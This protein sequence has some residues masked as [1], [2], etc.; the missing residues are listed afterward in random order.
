MFGA[1]VHDTRYAFRHLRQS[2]AFAAAAVLTLALGI[3]A[4]TAMFSVLNVLVLR[5]L[6]ITDPHGL[7]AMSAWNDRDQRM[8][9]LITS[10]PELQRDG[11][12]DPVCAFNGGG[13]FPA[14]VGG[15][16]TQSVIALITGRCFDVFG[17]AP[18]LG[19]TITDADAP[20]ERNPEMVAVIGHQ[21]WNRA[22]G[23]DPN[24]IGKTIRMEGAELTVIGV[25]PAGFVGIHAVG[26]IDLFVPNYTI[27]PRRPDRPHG[28]SHLLGRLK[29]GVPFE[30]AKAELEAR[31]PSLL[32]AT[33]PVTLTGSERAQFLETGA[34]V[35]RL[36]TGLSPYRDRYSRPVVIVLGLTLT[37]LLLACL[38]LGGLLLSR[39]AARAPEIAT[40]LALGATRRR[41][42]QQTVIESLYL[43]LSAAALAVP[44]SFGLVRVLVSFLPQPIVAQPIS[45]APDLRVVAVT[46]LCGIVAGVMISILPIW[47]GRR[48]AAMSFAWD[49]TIAGTT[50]RWT[51]G[52][53]VAQVAMSLVLLAG[54]VV[55][56]RS[57]YLLQ[58]ADRGFRSNELVAVYVSPLPNAYRT[59]DNA[60]YYPALLDRIKALPGV[61]SAALSRFFPRASGEPIGQP[62]AIKGEPPS[63]LR[64]QYETVSPGFFETVGVPLVAGRL[65]DWTDRANTQ[66]VAVVSESLARQLRPD[67]HVLGLRVA[68]GNQRA[69]QDVVIVGVVGNMSFGNPRATAFP[70]IYRPT[71]Q[72]G[73]LANNPIV[74]VAANENAPP[75]APSLRDIF[76]DAGREYARDI[77]SV[78]DVFTEG[79]SAERMSATLAAIT[80]VIAVALAFIGLY[81]LLAYSV[82]RRR[83]E[84]GV[85]LALGATRATLARMIVTDGLLLTLIGVAAGIPAAIGA[86][87][88]LRTLLFGVSA[89]DPMVLVVSSVV[90]LVVGASAGVVPALRAIAVDPAI[91]LR[92]E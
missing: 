37:L 55:L 50:S 65:A 19:R 84:M 46:G 18:V 7:I 74:I 88:F 31:W 49:R 64:A 82:S 61:R 54:A 26:G 42:A 70:S 12:L 11:P 45:F 15:A 85:R 6:P 29:P 48:N 80:A 91:T 53:L 59:I 30:K 73:L 23:G 43:S 13:L 86:G 20:L 33:V 72:A 75:L 76:K 56:A 77:R 10:V 79:P 35:E 4:N 16:P 1:L 69:D 32:Q 68:Y 57:L 24:V 78:D 62:I 81:G 21:F 89:A 40:R 58:H 3:A 34:R 27:T 47:L 83:R 38:N 51:R 14:E 71:L 22:F 9:T 44:I 87:Q 63:G 2:R 8:L 5:T 17:V 28:S 36:P 41:I 67:G 90:F 25:M 52:L 92:S 66:Q 39:M 60:S